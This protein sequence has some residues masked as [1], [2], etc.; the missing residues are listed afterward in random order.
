MDNGFNKKM[1]RYTLLFSLI[2][3]IVSFL[4]DMKQCPEE[5]YFYYFGL[6]LISFTVSI[7][8]IILNEKNNY[9]PKY[10]DIFFI[11]LTFWGC[12]SQLI[13]PQGYITVIISF[14]GL[15]LFTGNS[16]QKFM[17]MIIPAFL[18]SS[19]TIYFSDIFLP[20]D[21][22]NEQKKIDLIHSM[23]T[24]VS[25]ISVS[26]YLKNK[27]LQKVQALE[28][29]M[30]DLGS[31]SSIF[32]H[33]LKNLVGPLVNDSKLVLRKT[34]MED[35]NR[36]N[37]NLS[38]N[39]VHLKE[40]I[41][42][43]NQSFSFKE[44]NVNVDIKEVFSSI[45]KMYSKKM[46]DI[47]FDISQVDDFMGD[48]KAFKSILS[49]MIINSS[50]AF[51]SNKVENKKV[52]IVFK[53]KKLTYLDNAGGIPQE[54]IKAILEDS[55]FT[56]KEQGSGIGIYTIKKY[57]SLMGGRAHFENKDKGLQITI[58]FNK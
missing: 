47:S 52:S 22:I 44:E 11:F 41:L 48:P 26:Y 49:N 58:D 16:F 8:L 7:F 10:A 43:F 5:L 37:T 25:V 40:F 57:S 29:K 19:I 46:E 30:F 31:K 28:S 56:S 54:K 35:I 24:F 13:T 21:V 27:I 9:K 53:N 17:F 34:E 42:E 1:L 45:Q 18:I 4:N 39:I 32:I 55:F 20:L 36:I 3:Y 6:S 15:S 38:N 23:I 33:D 12:F 50:D 2:N 51:V 14:F